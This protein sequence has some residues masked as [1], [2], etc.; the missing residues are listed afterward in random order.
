M[1]FYQ[2]VIA[3]AV[4][5]TAATSAAFPTTAPQP[6]TYTVHNFMPDFWAFWT[7]ARNQPADQQARLWQQLYVA[8]HRAVFAELAAP[9]KDQFDPAVM[10]QEYFKSLPDW[11]PGMRAMADR[12]P[13]DMAEARRRFV[14]KFPDM[15][16]S[17]DVYVMASGGC[18]NGRVQKIQGRSALLLGVDNIVGLGEKNLVPVVD[19]ELFH[20][21]HH[22]Y[23]DFEPT[24]GYPLWTLLWAEGMATYVAEDLNPQASQIDLG[25]VPPGMVENVERER[26]KLAAEF[27]KHADSRADKDALVW[28][29]DI[30]S[31][32]PLV[33]PRA[34][35]ELGVLV[36]RELSKRYSMQ[37][38]AHWSR[39]EAEPK[40]RMALKAIAR[41][42]A[43]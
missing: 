17:G 28:F 38:M 33:P 1:R 8:H 4:L 30:D 7:V 6:S 3:F 20:R 21:Y 39:T 32:D 42:P 12:I 22:D 41:A 31:K 5:L 2:L 36:A 11:A 23:F 27:L 25:M 15:H 14:A 24:G 19:H 40:I 35:Y 37:Q 43:N 13:Q 9:C 18:F 10:R 16:W 26:R 29:N 34:G